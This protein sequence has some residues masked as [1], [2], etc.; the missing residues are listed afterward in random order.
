MAPPRQL[1]GAYPHD[2][3]LKRVVDGDAQVG[4]CGAER[5]AHHPLKE[6][7]DEFGAGA[8]FGA[9]PGGQF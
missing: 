6:S 5:S 3:V 9:G 4:K 1:G 8:E 7:I 2:S